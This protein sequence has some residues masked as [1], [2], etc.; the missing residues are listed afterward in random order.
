MQQIC[1]MYRLTIREFASI[2]DISKGH[3]EDIIKHRKFPAL[4]LGVVIARY[5]ECSVED[6]FGWRVD[7]DG[8]RRP[9]LVVEPKTGVA[10]R[11]SEREKSEETMP[12]IRERIAGN[13]LRG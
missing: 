10:Y 8:K 7:D 9:L 13:G 11:L 3:A 4:D 12:L 2:F 5:F 1:Q 6:L